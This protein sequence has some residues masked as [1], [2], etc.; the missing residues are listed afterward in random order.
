MYRVNEPIDTMP[1]LLRVRRDGFAMSAVGPVYT[2][3]R[4]FSGQP[5]LHIRARTVPAPASHHQL[6]AVTGPAG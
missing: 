3:L 1:R 2:Q 4:T 6:A 5:S